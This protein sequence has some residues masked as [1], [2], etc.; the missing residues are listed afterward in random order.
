MGRQEWVQGR[1]QG[2]GAGA[3]ASPREPGQWHRGWEEV[4]ELDPY[5]GARVQRL[6]QCCDSPENPCSST[7][8]GLA[9]PARSHEEVLPLV[10]CL[11]RQ[12]P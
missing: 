2:A 7:L 12:S 4:E 1:E 11:L 9:P 5:L 10:G 3:G 6:G 8:A